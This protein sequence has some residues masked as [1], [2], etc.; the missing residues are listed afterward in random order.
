MV[1]DGEDA[2]GRKEGLGVESSHPV[3]LDAES[4]G[5]DRRA[6]RRRRP[7]ILAV[8]KPFEPV[9]DPFA[10]AAPDGLEGRQ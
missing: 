3:F 7:S 2:V 6:V 9:L 5:A 4:T 1:Y 10:P 8:E